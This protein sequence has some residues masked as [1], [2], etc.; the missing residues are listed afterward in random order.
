MIRRIK[1]TYYN[2]FNGEFLGSSDMP[3]DRMKSVNGYYLR[4]WKLWK[5]F[6]SETYGIDK[7]WCRVK[8][9]YERTVTPSPI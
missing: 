4:R 6:L 8:I 1:F 7:H 5:K 3:F 9:S 2:S